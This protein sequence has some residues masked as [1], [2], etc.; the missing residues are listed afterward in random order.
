M[1]EAYISIPDWLLN[2]D[3]NT[4]IGSVDISEGC[5]PGGLNNAIRELMAELRDDFEED[6]CT[7]TL[8]DSLG[9]SA[10][11][12][13]DN[14]FQYHRRGNMVFVA[15]TLNWS[16]TTA[17]NSASRI[18]ITGLPYAVRNVPGYRV[19][20]IFGPST[21]GSVLIEREELAFY[22]APNTNYLVG[23]KIAAT[24][25][26]GN[27]VKTDLGSTGTLYALQFSYLTDYY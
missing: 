5:A 10:T 18:R 4:T 21:S 7:L 6:S 15:G 20:A 12:G 3:L 22:A 26:D 11:M 24:N 27:L 13:A 19:S 17:L 25:T 1:R 8:A 14:A 9:N 23:S 2:P 16:A